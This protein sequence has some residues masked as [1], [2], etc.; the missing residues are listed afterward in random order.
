MRRS[1]A[2]QL[3]VSYVPVTEALY[4]LELDGLVQNFPKQGC[5]VRELT[6]EQIQND[7]VIRE[8]LECQSARIAAEKGTDE[9]FSYLLQHAIRLDR[10]LWDGDPFSSLGT[11]MHSELHLS[12][13]QISGLTTFVGEL[14]KV[15]KQ[16][17]ARWNWI[18]ATFFKKPPQGWHE[19]L[20]REIMSR[21][22]ERAEKKMREHTRY[23]TDVDQDAFKKIIDQI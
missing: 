13:A 14:Q 12:I 10:V 17:L 22:P 6:L 18:S 23:G 7:F 3:G 9:Q 16:Y 2:K 20:V 4:M 5:R 15:W 11:K 1:V 19:Q 21:D 8:A